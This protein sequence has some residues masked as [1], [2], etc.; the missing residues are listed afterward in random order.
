M[1]NRTRSSRNNIIK[2]R[3]EIIQTAQ[4]NE[5]LLVDDEQIFYFV[6][7]SKKDFEIKYW[8]CSE[9]NSRCNMRIHTKGLNIVKEVGKHSHLE[10]IE[11]VEKLKALSFLKNQI[12]LN[13]VRVKRTYNEY[14][15]NNLNKT[16]LPKFEKIR[17][18]LYRAAS[19]NIP[20][21]PKSLKDIDISLPFFKIDPD[22]EENI[23]KF[24][25]SDV[26]LICLEEF[27]EELTNIENLVFYDGT[28]LSCPDIWYQL[29]PLRLF[30]P[31]K[32]L[33]ITVAYGLLA[34]KKQSTY[35]EFF[36]ILNKL[37]KEKTGKNIN[38][39]E[40][41]CDFEKGIM[42]SAN[43]IYAKLAKGCAFHYFNVQRLNVLKLGLSEIVKIIES[44]E[45]NENGMIYRKTKFLC[46]MPEEMVESMFYKIKSD[47]S[48]IMYPYLNYFEKT[49]V[50]SYQLS[51]WNYYG[52][53]EMKTNNYSEGENH[54]L[55]DKF[56]QK[57][58]FHRLVK[59]LKIK[60]RFA[61]R[62]YNLTKKRNVNDV[63]DPT[64]SIMDD[65]V[66]EFNKCISS[67]KMNVCFKFLNKFISNDIDKKY[68][69]FFK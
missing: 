42:N 10:P 15:N 14:I 63:V 43:K 35:L 22:S 36:K 30:I 53:L 2:A 26:L 34:N 65:F 8:T 11:K 62:D 16:Y 61:V 66:N 12:K 29:T 45:I 59:E 52:Q 23:I 46:Y 13:P 50:K 31:R 7:E 21:E 47:S 9:K 55:N 67:K 32:Q 49:C 1:N 64:D 37:V 44:N 56:N 18:A 5:S 25:N 39:K 19:I 27:Y 69:K 20:K 28:F 40:I 33:C 57:P 24:I 6:G 51:T 60:L 68:M 3:V 4:N 41:H 58:G 54:S 48:K 17:N 38:C